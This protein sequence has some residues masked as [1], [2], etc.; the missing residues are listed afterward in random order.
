VRARFGR[1]AGIAVMGCVTLLAAR[2]PA[3]QR[4]A[5]EQYLFNAVNASRAAAGLP[6]LTWN[7]SLTKAAASHAELMR[8]ED[9]LTHQFAEEPDLPERVASKGIR[10][11]VIAENVGLSDSA[12]DL[13]STFMNSPDHRDNILDQHVNAVGISVRE[14]RGELWA[15]E[16][17]AQTVV[18]LSYEEQ[19]Q[20]VTA[21]LK[22]AGLKKVNATGTARDTCRK[23]TGF[24]G[25]QPAFLLRFT[26]A[27]LARLP[28]QLVA[29]LA[30]G[31][32]GEA[33]VGACQA[34]TALQFSSYS[35]AVLLYR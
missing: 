12:V 9:S 6:A 20:Q 24:V 18:E 35:I 28:Q 11:T 17:F 13:H 33:A 8:R 32:I 29:R 34:T 30:K 3:Q 14:E 19:E 5:A 25:E 31:G 15:V 1:F 22:A 4:T 26:S 7:E 21:L 27:D 16:D 2:S 10:F 23:A